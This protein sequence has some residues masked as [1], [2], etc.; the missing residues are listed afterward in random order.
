M[1]ENKKKRS[2]KRVVSILSGV[3]VFCTTYALI[4]PAV[5]M[6]KETYCGMEAH[7]HTEACYRSQTPLCGEEEGEPNEGHVHDETCYEEVRNLIC[8]L[9]ES[10][11]HIHTDECYETTTTQTCGK[12]ES[13]P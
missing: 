7:V 8:G 10:E 5:T 13:E 2:W 11:T 6:S 3:V 1:K 4:L 9:E 12:E